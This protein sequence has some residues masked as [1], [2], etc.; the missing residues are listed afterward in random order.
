[1]TAL[2]RATQIHGTHEG[3]EKLARWRS[4]VQRYPDWEQ[5]TGDE[6]QCRCTFHRVRRQRIHDYA[7]IGSGWRAKVAADLQWMRKQT[8]KVI[9]AG[10]GNEWLE[11]IRE[12]EAV[13]CQR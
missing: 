13:G 1:M 10:M 9:T 5:C 2:E 6:V 8:P 3:A 4:F 7:N 12:T 11:L